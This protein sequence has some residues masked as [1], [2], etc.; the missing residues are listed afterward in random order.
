MLTREEAKKLLL[1]R[2]KDQQDGRSIAEERTIERPFGWVFF[3]L[4]PGSSATR[5]AKPVI[6][7]PV[8]V[9]KYVE[10]V[11]ASSTEYAPER[12]VEIYEKLLAESRASGEGWCL[13]LSLPVPRGRF[14][15]RRLAERAR[16]AGFYEIRSQHEKA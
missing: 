4:A 10:Q 12:F 2:L 14:R 15:W 11:I 7:G 8:I 13:T 16:E 9:N 1:A 6:E 5:G 3:L